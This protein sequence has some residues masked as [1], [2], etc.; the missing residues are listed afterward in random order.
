M[1]HTERQW[2]NRS[3]YGAFMMI[4]MMMMTSSIRYIW[5]RISFGISC[6]KK[7]FLCW[8]SL[9][10]IWESSAVNSQLLGIGVLHVFCWNT[11]VLHAHV[12]TSRIV[13][14]IIS[15][16]RQLPFFLMV[17]PWCVWKCVYVKTTHFNTNHTDLISPNVISRKLCRL[18]CR[19]VCLTDSSEACS[20][21]E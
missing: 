15:F 13:P 20:C 14:C 5:W 19:S 11:S 2:F 4:L 3:Q 12:V 6:A 18:L 10:T 9:V 7:L 1:Y 16:S 21:T 8:Y 17:W